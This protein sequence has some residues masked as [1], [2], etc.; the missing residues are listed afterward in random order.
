[1][2]LDLRIT[3]AATPHTSRPGDR[4]VDTLFWASFLVWGSFIGL[5]ELVADLKS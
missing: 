4:A 3:L 2:M 5:A 1:M